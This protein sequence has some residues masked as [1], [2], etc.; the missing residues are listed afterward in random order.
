MN[1]EP[2]GIRVQGSWL[3]LGFRVQ[4]GAFYDNQR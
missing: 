3:G 2:R 4:G 1:P